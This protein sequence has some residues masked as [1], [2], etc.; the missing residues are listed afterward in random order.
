MQNFQALNILIIIFSIHHGIRSKS[1]IYIDLNHDRL[2]YISILQ[3]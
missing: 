3:L 1:V 2:Y